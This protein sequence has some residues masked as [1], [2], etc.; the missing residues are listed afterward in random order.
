MRKFKFEAAPLVLA[1][2]VTTAAS[3]AAP[4]IAWAWRRRG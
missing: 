4:M 3:L 1:L 2:L